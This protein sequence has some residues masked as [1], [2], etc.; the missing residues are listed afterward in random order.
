MNDL[1]SL[2]IDVFT[3]T[4]LDEKQSFLLSDLDIYDYLDYKTKGFEVNRTKIIIEEMEFFYNAIYSTELEHRVLEYYTKNNKEI[5]YIK[6]PLLDMEQ[7]KKA[8]D[9]IPSKKQAYTPDFDKMTA[10]YRFFETYKFHK[11]INILKSKLKDEDIT[12]NTAN[13][14]AK[15]YLL[16]N[17]NFK[18]I[19]D[20][21]IKAKLIIMEGSIYKWL[22]TKS[23]LAYFIS[24]VSDE[25]EL[26][27]SNG[28]IQWKYFK[29]LFGYDSK[30]NSLAGA[31]N[32]FKKVGTF[33]LGYEIIDNLF[34]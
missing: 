31:L 20:K 7:T 2:T 8:G 15:S 33:P 18:L 3:D 17:N 28:R 30:D 27:P 16:N 11:V 13:T 21:A 24:K 12:V 22:K 14:T 1:K 23:L 9:F 4:L 34:K 10:K 29:P 19:I 25:L 5:P 6:L 26:S 32:D